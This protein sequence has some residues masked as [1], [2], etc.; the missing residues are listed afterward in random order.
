MFYLKKNQKYMFK[1]DEQTNIVNCPTAY[2]WV[3]AVGQAN[4]LVIYIE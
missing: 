1:I 2:A 4:R 3:G